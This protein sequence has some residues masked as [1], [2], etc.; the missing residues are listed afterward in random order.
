MKLQSLCTK[1]CWNQKTLLASI[2]NYNHVDIAAPIVPIPSHSNMP[3]LLASSF[4]PAISIPSIQVNSFGLPNVVLIAIPCQ[5]DGSAKNQCI[6][7]RR[8]AGSACKRN[9][10]SVDMSQNPGCGISQVDQTCHFTGLIQYIFNIR[11]IGCD[12]SIPIGDFLQSLVQIVSRRQGDG[13]CINGGSSSVQ[14]VGSCQ[15]TK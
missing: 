10:G 8:E 1:A 4:V 7:G 11:G 14:D 5:F 12:A 3:P 6:T 2:T 15:D 9:P 13:S